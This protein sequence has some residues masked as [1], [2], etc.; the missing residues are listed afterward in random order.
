[1]RKCNFSDYESA[2]LLGILEDYISEYG[3]KEWPIRMKP[4]LLNIITE[5]GGSDELLEYIG[6]I[7]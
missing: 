6:G 4:A 3:R 2:L 1:M 5:L 7:L